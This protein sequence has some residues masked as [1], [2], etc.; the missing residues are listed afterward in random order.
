M[1]RFFLMF[2]NFP[3]SLPNPLQY[4]K[5]YEQHLQ[6][7]LFQCLPMLEKHR[8]ATLYFPFFCYLSRYSHIK[9]FTQLQAYLKFTT[10]ITTI[11][12]R[13]QREKLTLTFHGNAE[14]RRL[15]LLMCIHS[16]FTSQL[17]NQLQRLYLHN[18]QWFF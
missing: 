14:P 11:K 15:M 10:R 18:T 8:Q 17:R 6:N 9:K 2:W 13:K 7:H 16:Q 4:L 1:C 5:C 3:A 12:I